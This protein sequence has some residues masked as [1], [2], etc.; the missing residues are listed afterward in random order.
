MPVLEKLQKIKCELRAPKDS[1]NSFGKFAYRNAEGILAA[2]KPLEEKYN[3]VVRITDELT[4]TCGNA[5]VKANVVLHDL[6]DSSSVCSSAY[7]REAEQKKGMDAMQITGC[8]SSYARKYALSALFCIDNEKDSDAYAPDD[9][10]KE[11]VCADCGNVLKPKKKNGMV[12]EP[13]EVAEKSMKVHKR[14]LCF[15]CF[16]AANRKACEQP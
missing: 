5:Y 15:D 9:E 11:F 1:Y 4:E 8:A 7:A 3:V 16:N 6:D 14:V 2:L 10:K 13:E 12:Y